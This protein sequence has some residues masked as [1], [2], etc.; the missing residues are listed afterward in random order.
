MGEHDWL[1]ERFEAERSHLR[2]VAYRMLGSLVEAD[3]AVQETWLRLSR[4]DTSNIQNLGAWLTTVIGRVCFDMLRAR[5]SRR[6][7]LLEELGPE[8]GTRPEDTIDPEEEALM[9]DSV[10]LAL[11]VV[12]DSLN[13]AERLAFVLHDLFDASFEEIAPIVGRSPTA[14]RQLASRAR[15]RVRGVGA[16]P[17]ADLA[18]QR[19]V[20]D[21]FLAASRAGDFEALL[22]LLDPAV[23]LRAD[24]AA[25]AAGSHEEIRGA[26]AVA[27][28]F[29]GRA[30]NARPALVNGAVGAVVVLRG[31]LFLTLAITVKDGKIVE[32]SAVADP[33][34]LRQLTLAILPDGD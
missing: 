26:A 31:R 34:R 27:K 13:P 28:Q 30:Q 10:G 16:L 22:T 1:A 24:Q 5:Q 14:A 6:E 2:A 15:R 20:V 12:L 29:L 4:A 23:V 8:L 7:E 32:I 19:H 21:A 25:V 9:A 18:P 3:D 11:L 33:E 17:D